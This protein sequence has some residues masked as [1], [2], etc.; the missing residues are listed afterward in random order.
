MT[1]W[2]QGRTNTLKTVRVLAI[3]NLDKVLNLQLLMSNTTFFGL[4]RWLSSKKKKNL[5]MQETQKMHVRSPSQEGP[6]EKEMATHSSILAWKIPWAEEPGGLQSKRVAKSWT[7]A[8]L[9][10][11]LSH[12]LSFISFYLP[13]TQLSCISLGSSGGGVMCTLSLSFVHPSLCTWL[14]SLLPASSPIYLITLLPREEWE[15][16]SAV[17]GT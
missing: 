6:T 1:K 9:S 2:V 11:G 8:N 13:Q 14:C 16:P 4:P 5:P 15:K 3:R 7:G 12:T 10:S 17:H